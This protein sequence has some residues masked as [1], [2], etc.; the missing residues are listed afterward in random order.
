VAS[1][2]Q[3]LKAR[4]AEDERVHEPGPYSHSSHA[5]DLVGTFN[6]QCPDCLGVGGY[7][8]AAEAAAKRAVLTYLIGLTADQSRDA[9]TC[10]QFRSVRWVVEQIAAIYK[11]HP[12]YQQEWASA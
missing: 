8:M 3:F 7:R 5:Y 12:D 6:A 1:I 11:D 9:E 10:A 4:I 2:V